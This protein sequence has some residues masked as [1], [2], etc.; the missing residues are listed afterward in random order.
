MNYTG[1]QETVPG[2]VIN[3]EKSIKPYKYTYQKKKASTQ[4]PYKNRQAQWERQ[5]VDENWL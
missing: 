2:R 4:I 1:K 3:E 5:N